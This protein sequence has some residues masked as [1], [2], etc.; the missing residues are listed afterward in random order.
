MKN[1]LFTYATRELS[2]DAFICYLMSFALTDAKDDSI[3][4]NCAKTF[5]WEM[6]SET[7]GKD[8]VLTDVERQVGNIDVLLTAICDGKKYKIAVEDKTYTSEHSNQLL[9][10]LEYL[11][12]KYP[13]FTPCGVY[14]KTSFQSDLSAVKEA[15][16]RIITRKKMLELLAPCVAQINN[17][18]ILDYFEYW[19]EFEEVAQE[20]QK[21]PLDQWNDWR[22]VNGFYEALKN[23]DFAKEKQIWLDYDYVPNRSGGFYGLWLG[24]N[25]NTFTILDVPCALYLQIEAV[26]QVDKYAL[27]I[28]LKLELRDENSTAKEIRE[29]VVYDESW[30]YRLTDYNFKRPNRFASGRHMTIGVYNAEYETAAELQATLAAAVDDYARLLNDL[31]NGCLKRI[32]TINI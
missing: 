29:A 1:N 25:E 32:F 12:N 24:F 7:A 5:L 4:R 23:S 21:K 28:Y 14:Y 15:G 2:Q 3:L 16:Y 22:H 18:I 11:H 20:Y 30:N 13:D 6:L 27:P 17:Q 8:I 9:R 26:Q 19:N 31:R 10:Y